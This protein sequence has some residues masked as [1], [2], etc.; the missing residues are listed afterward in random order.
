MRLACAIVLLAAGVS[1]A[2]TNDHL[3]PR[4]KSFTEYRQL[5]R[6]RL[7]IT[8][9]DCGRILLI[10]DL[11]PEAAISVY[12]S[13]NHFYIT[14]TAASGHGFWQA[15]ETHERVKVKRLDRDIRSEIAVAIRRAITA[16]LSDVRPDPASAQTIG[17]D[18][19]LFEVSLQTPHGIVRGDS[20][21]EPTGPRTKGLEQLCQLLIDYCE[22]PAHKRGPIEARIR[23]CVTSV[24]QK[25]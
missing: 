19:H 11:G 2:A 25:T 18:I 1:P 14:E 4:S 12:K 23:K 3:V 10:P 5:V 24:L 17:A 21:R 8:P 15:R 20:P 13:A 16:L 22:A 7:A 6:S 9:F